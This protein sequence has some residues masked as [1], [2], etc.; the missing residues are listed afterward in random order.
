MNLTIT[1]T[2]DHARAVSLLHRL[3]ARTCFTHVHVTRGDD[4]YCVDCRC[5]VAANGDGHALD[6][7]HIANPTRED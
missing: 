5:D 7:P 1:L 3:L 4:F 6:C 2:V